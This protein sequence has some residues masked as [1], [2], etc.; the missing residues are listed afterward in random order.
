[1]EVHTGAF[2]KKWTQAQTGAET[3]AQNFVNWI[4]T[5]VFCMDISS[6]STVIWHHFLDTL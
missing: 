4:A 3:R 6:K 2:L 5:M 1:M